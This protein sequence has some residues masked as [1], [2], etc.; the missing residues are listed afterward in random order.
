MRTRKTRS[1]KKK[2]QLPRNLSRLKLLLRSSLLSN[3]NRSNLYN[4]S[5]R[6]RPLLLRQSLLHSL[7]SQLNRKSLLFLL[8]M[9]LTMKMT[10]NTTMRMM[11]MTF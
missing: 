3:L 10:K 4:Q 6:S 9:S 2:S 5:R 11:L 8:R 1:L 7:R